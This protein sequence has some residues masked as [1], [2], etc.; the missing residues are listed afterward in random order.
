MY[1]VDTLALAPPVRRGVPASGTASWRPIAAAARLAR[2]GRARVS[3]TDLLVTVAAGAAIALM[4]L[5]AGEGIGHT[6]PTT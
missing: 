3:A 4:V 6:A 2:A 1:P 5:L